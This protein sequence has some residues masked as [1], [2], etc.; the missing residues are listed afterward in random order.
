MSIPNFG[1]TSAFAKFS[2]IL[3]PNVTAVT[4]VL[5]TGGGVVT[6]TI[7]ELF[8]GLLT[9]DCD[10]AQTYTTPTAAL[11]VAGINGCVVGTS[12]D[13]DVINYGDTT[14]TIGLG[15]GVTKVTIHTVAAVL[16]LATLT[17][18]RLKFVVTNVTPG[19]EAV[20]LYAFG[21]TAAAVA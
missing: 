3:F 2:T 1:P 5:T 13:V 17:A 4:K 9:F 20:V 10:D 11:I 19:S 14:L 15:T 6:G 8:S 21:S 12:F 7:A 16:T 18:K